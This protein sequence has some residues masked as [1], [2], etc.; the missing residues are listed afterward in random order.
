MQMATVAMS[1]QVRNIFMFIV[2]QY[3]QQPPSPAELSCDAY[4]IPGE[5][6]DTQVNTS[7]N[8]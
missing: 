2:L 7:T 3:L 4:S 8:Q 1:V 6:V 5:A